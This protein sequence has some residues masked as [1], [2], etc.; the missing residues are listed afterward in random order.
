MMKEGA[1]S[2]INHQWQPRDLHLQHLLGFES[3]GDVKEVQ[4]PQSLGKQI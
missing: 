1:I 3:E 4:K 2:L